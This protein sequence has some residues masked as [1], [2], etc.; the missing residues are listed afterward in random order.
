[1]PYKFQTD[2]IPMPREFDKRV[3]LSEQD[4]IDIVELYKSG[5]TSQRKLARQFD[6][7]KR[8]I[9][10]V[11]DPKKKEENLKR[12]DERGGSKIYYDK[13]KNTESVRKHLRYKRDVLKG[14]EKEKKSEK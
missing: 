9:Q 12:R 8:T 11:L 5:N 7:D 1:M 6:V 4:K 3:K 14:I 10:F 2:K 13:E